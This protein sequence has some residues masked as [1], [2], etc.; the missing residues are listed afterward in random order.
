MKDLVKLFWSVII[1]KGINKVDDKKFNERMS[2]C[3]SNSCKSYQKPFN[4][5]AL[6]RCGDCG[7]F[8]NAKARIDEFYIKCPKDLW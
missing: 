8:L 5:K 3:R 6:E 7:C 2:I 4:I 1:G